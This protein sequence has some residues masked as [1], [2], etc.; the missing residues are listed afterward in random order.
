MK[1]RGDYFLL[2][3][4]FIFL[5]GFTSAI[6][7]TFGTYKT[8]TDLTLTQTCANCSY[9]NITSIK[10]PNGSVMLTDV[11]MTKSGSSYSYVL[12]GGNL[13]AR[14]VY[15]VNGLGDPEGNLEIWSYDFEINS[16][17]DELTDSKSI[18]FLGALFLLGS[19]VVV[20]FFV[21]R[22][23]QFND[24]YDE[25][26]NLIQIYRSKYIKHVLYMLIYLIIFGMIWITANFTEGYFENSMISTLFF[27]LFVFAFAGLIIFV[28]AYVVYLFILMYEDG[29]KKELLE[30]GVGFNTF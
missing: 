12:G 17:G 23:L 30:R 16:A 2:C 13:S 8:E 27:S 5:I 15:L 4:L 1:F 26:G 11:T 14:G 6:D 21:T 25:N 18:A 22:N 9:N 20:I 28:P 29:I 10:Y 19:L 3:F 7:T 24:G